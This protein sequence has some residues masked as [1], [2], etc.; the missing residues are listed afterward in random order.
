MHSYSLAGDPGIF[1]K[2]TAAHA[3]KGCCTPA[4]I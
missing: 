1:G 2:P 3:G 4:A